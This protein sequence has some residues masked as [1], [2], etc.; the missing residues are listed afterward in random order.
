MTAARVR[1]V[2][3]W[4]LVP[5]VLAAGLVLALEGGRVARPRSPWFGRPKAFTL[6]DAIAQHDVARAYALLRETRRHP[7]ELIV[8][9]H[10][11]LTAGVGRFVSPL[12][13]AVAMRDE[14]AI[15]MLLGAGATIQHVDGRDA[16]CLAE[17]LHDPVMLAVLRR[18]G[19]ALPDDPCPTVPAAR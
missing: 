5:G 19:P 6:G 9:S 8:V 17:R 14:H 12:W 11:T 15:L 13:W 4:L 7:D 2:G 18:G 3:A 10:P 16:D 1:S